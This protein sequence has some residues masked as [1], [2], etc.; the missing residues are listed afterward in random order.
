MKRIVL[1][2]SSPRRREILKN[3]GFKFEI[4]PSAFDETLVDLNFSYEKIEQLAY[5]KALAVVGCVDSDFLVIGADTV[6]VFDDKILGKPKDKKDAINMLKQLSG[7]V[8]SVVT[9]ICIIDAETMKFKKKSV[10][11]YVEFNELSDKDI[12]SYINDFNP[13]DKAGAYGIQELSKN[14]IKR[15]DGSFENVVGLCP[16]SVSELLKE[17]SV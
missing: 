14:F 9:S 2:S 10:T 13:L 4:I 8:H 11:T 3:A 6:V 17:I 5:Q 1:A 7:K 15:I 12:K 16:S